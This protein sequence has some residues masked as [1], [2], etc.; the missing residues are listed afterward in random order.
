MPSPAERLA[1]LNITLPAPV[2][3]VANYVPFVRVGALLHV[4]GQVSTASAGSSA[5]TWI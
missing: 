1:A 4:S 2:A 3:P 5:R